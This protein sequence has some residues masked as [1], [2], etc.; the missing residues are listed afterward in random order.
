MITHPVL[1]KSIDFLYFS[2]AIHER[3]ITPMRD[4]KTGGS[5]AALRRHV[6]E[7]HSNAYYARTGLYLKAAEPFFNRGQ[8][9]KPRLHMTKV[10][11][12]DWFS[13]LYV[14]DT[15]RRLVTEI[16]P[17]LTDVGG[18]DL[19]ISHDCTKSVMKRLGGDSRGTAA[20]VSNYG[21]NFNGQLIHSGVT[22]SDDVRFLRMQG[23]IFIVRW[24]KHGWR[25]PLA[26]YKDC[27]CCRL[28][29]GTVSG[30]IFDPVDE[31]TGELLCKMY[32]ID[33]ATA[34]DEEPKWVLDEE[35]TEKMA[36]AWRNIKVRNHCIY[37]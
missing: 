29:E 23:K 35:L 7:A 31:N 24:A 13:D 15:T 22:P 5:A 37:H 2:Y 12:D 16:L 34:D 17:A 32:K 26:I 19:I 11:S 33:P 18:H 9:P 14:M 30:E 20:F 1:L 36:D 21:N 28:E 10:P 3:V 27:S 6:S 4:P 8:Q 25:P